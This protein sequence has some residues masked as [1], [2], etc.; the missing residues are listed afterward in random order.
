[1]AKKDLEDNN[2]PE[3]DFEIDIKQKE[4][5]I[6]QMILQYDNRIKRLNEEIEKNEDIIKNSKDF[7]AKSIMQLEISKNFYELGIQNI[8]TQCND[9]FSK[10]KNTLNSDFLIYDDLT[11]KTEVFEEL[12][13]SIDGLKS[14]CIL[15]RDNNNNIAVMKTAHT[16]K[17]SLWNGRLSV[18]ILTIVQI[19][20]IAPKIEAAP[21]KWRLKI[22]K[23]TAPPEWAIIPERGG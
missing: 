15:S 5:T 9:V 22:A 11:L 23:S 13:K 8:I 16:N 3:Y 7:K 21:D 2:Y 4:E 20:L 14:S 1:M 10:L 12:K 19:K 18:L 6:E 17:G